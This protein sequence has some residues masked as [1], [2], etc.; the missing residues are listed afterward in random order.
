[1]P[2]IKI[3]TENIYMRMVCED[4]AKFI[5]S[6][7]TDS[8]NSRYLS[9]TSPSIHNQKDWIR[10]YK[11]R[12]NKGEEYYFIA[13]MNSSNEPFGTT[14]LYDF[15]EDTFTNGSW[16]VKRGMEPQYPILIDLLVRSYAFRE[17]GFSKC[18]FDVR[19]GNKKVIKYHK[20]LGAKFVRSD[21][22]NNYYTIQKK[23]FFMSTKKL[24]KL[25]IIQ[26][27]D[28]QYSVEQEET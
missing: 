25:E 16:V 3:Y 9:K 13:C 26:E 20:M 8:K 11:E 24:L 4:D 12:E 23:D 19:K 5:V 28:L 27:K 2:Y 17:L 18:F 21:D 10:K 7:R 22:L 1:M 6:L 15:Q 14:R